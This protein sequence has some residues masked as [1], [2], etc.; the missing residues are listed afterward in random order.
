MEN[1]FKKLLGLEVAKLN[2]LEKN[3]EIANK[4]VEDLKEMLP[5]ESLKRPDYNSFHI[6]KIGQPYSITKQTQIAFSTKEVTFRS[7]L[8]LHREKVC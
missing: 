1:Q 6:G 7:R 5:M 8:L 4:I 2:L 3:K